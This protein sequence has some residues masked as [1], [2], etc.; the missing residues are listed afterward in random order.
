MSVATTIMADHHD[1]AEPGK[2]DKP[3]GM[4]KSA[5]I[6][7]IVYTYLRTTGP[8]LNIYW[9]TYLNN[10]LDKHPSPCHSVFI[11]Q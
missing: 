9:A 4:H 8:L 2:I 3:Q 7:C 10:G 11:L 6:R 5:Q 1:T